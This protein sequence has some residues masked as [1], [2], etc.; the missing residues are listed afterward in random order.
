MAE[1]GEGLRSERERRGMSLEAICAETK[2]SPRHLAALEREDYKALPSG[3]FRRGI[4]RA[5]LRSLGLDEQVWMPRF[6]A[7][8]GARMGT[9][10]DSGPDEAALAT[11]ALNVK[12]NRGAQRR[13]QTARWIGVMLLGLLVAA[14]GWAVWNF[15]LR[16]RHGW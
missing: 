12:K 15:M 14:T 16:G 6:E 1:F 5:Y 8:Y 2:V 9:R 11:F 10:S 13:S 4:V 7:S 3:V